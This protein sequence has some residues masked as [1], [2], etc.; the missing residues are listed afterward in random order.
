MILRE[1]RRDRETWTGRLLSAP[2]PGIKKPE[3]FQHMGTRPRPSPPARVQGSERLCRR[4]SCITR[5]LLQLCVVRRGAAAAFAAKGPG[6]AQAPRGGVAA[7]S[8]P[9]PPPEPDP[10][11]RNGATRH[12]GRFFKPTQRSDRGPGS[13][14]SPCQGSAVQQGSGSAGWNHDKPG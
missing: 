5:A 4:P 7:F 12:S 13:T 10:P 2:R 11:C 8:T 14:W 1:R 6:S 3:P 9:L